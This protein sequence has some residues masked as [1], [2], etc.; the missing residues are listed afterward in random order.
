MTRA[1]YFIGLHSLLVTL[2]FSAADVSWTEVTMEAPSV[3][4]KKK[5]VK[6]KV[7]K[8]KVK[9]E[10]NDE[11]IKGSD[12]ENEDHVEETKTA[13]VSMLEPVSQGKRVVKHS[14]R[15]QQMVKNIDD[16]IVL[17]LF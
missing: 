11:K 1:C 16:A 13:P 8:K 2:P 15:L 10:K 9:T 3:E 14:I 7:L 5:R 4:V 12:G 6:K 17:F